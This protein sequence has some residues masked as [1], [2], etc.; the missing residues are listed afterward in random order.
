MATNIPKT[1]SAVD[2]Q[3]GKGGISALYINASTPTPTPTATQAL[4]KIHAFGL[5][6]MDLLQREGSYPLPPQAPS[7]LGVEFSGT[8]VSFGSADH[9]RG[10]SI[11]DA[12]FG[13]AY[14]G[15]YAEYI[16]VS[17]HMLIRKP[18]ELSWEEAAGI[19]ETWITASQALWMVGG[20]GEVVEGKG[21]K[22]KRVLWHAGASGVSL[23]GVQLCKGEGVKEVLVTA[24]SEEKIAWAKE[25]A[26]ADAGFSYKDP[27]K[28][29]DEAV[30]EHTGGEGVDL[31]VDF[32]GGPYFDGNLNAAAKNGR[33]VSLG[34]MGGPKVNVE[35][36]VDIG[37]FLRKRLRFEGSTLRA[38]DE[39]YQGKLRDL[40]VEHALPRF[41]DGRFK[42]P[43]EKVFKWTDIQEAH[44]EM[45]RNTSKGKLIC[46]V[47]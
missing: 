4:I 38:R 32:V 25:F 16:A 12:V 41:K 30:L 27:N 22:D 36:G 15:A 31:I 10:F 37:R 17:T 46:V 21:V 2:I 13:L 19:P 18:D 24:S 1:M 6:R 26:G 33:I 8:I 20:L 42:V 5:N 11:G 7:T 47:E 35:G 40:L 14:G 9:E 23:S 44:R 29:W 3:G 39:E 45:E 34:T 43:V 28:S